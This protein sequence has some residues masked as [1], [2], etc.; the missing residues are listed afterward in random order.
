MDRP[1]PYDNDDADPRAD[2]VFVLLAGVNT[3]LRFGCLPVLP[4]TRCCSQSSWPP[5]ISSRRDV[6]IDRPVAAD[7]PPRFGVDFT[8]RADRRCIDVMRTVWRDRVA[9]PRPHP[10]DMKLTTYL[11]Q[12]TIL[13]V[14][15]AQRTA[16]RA[17]RLAAFLPATN[18]GDPTAD[19]AAW[20]TV[21]RYARDAGR[22]DGAVESASRFA[23]RRTGSRSAPA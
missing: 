17:G 19:W 3:T 20:A 10:D 13:I 9:A 12:P 14:V 7:S 18:M 6:E 2:H 1:V 23:R 11:V 21:Q 8:R 15:A 5:P 22:P 16:A 4:S